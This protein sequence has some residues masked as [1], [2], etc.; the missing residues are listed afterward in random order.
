MILCI[1]GFRHWHITAGDA[2]NLEQASNAAK[3]NV[4]AR[5]DPSDTA[6]RPHSRK[7][8]QFLVVS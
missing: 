4:T 8:V 2:Y 5:A 1:C 3:A 6:E 7:W